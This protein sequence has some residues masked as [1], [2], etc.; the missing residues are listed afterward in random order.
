[1]TVDRADADGEGTEQVQL[2]VYDRLHERAER[3]RRWR[4]W[5]LAAGHLVV[6][7]ILAYAFVFAA[8]RFVALTPILYGIVVMDGLQSGVK[9]LYLQQHLVELEA[10]LAEREPLA[11][12][13]TRFGVF[14][15]DTAV[16]VWDV[17][18]NTVPR[19]A[20]YLL[21]LGIYVELIAAS[22]V[23]WD[24]LV[25]PGVGLDITRPILLLGY[26]T[27]TVLF[28]GIVVVGYLH[29]ERVRSAI[30]DITDEH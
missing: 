23:V 21:V 15:T 2:A 24:P 6:G 1:M 9:T 30:R 28:G 22:L 3:E 20:Q 10:K 25:T 5:R 19:T 18:L 11:D 14:G 8:W 7:V 26:G 4:L 29:Y 16:E 17:D 13:V 27:F 12:Y